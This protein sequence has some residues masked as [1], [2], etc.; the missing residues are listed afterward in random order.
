MRRKWQEK[1][2]EIKSFKVSGKKVS[3]IS[4]RRKSPAGLH[5]GDKY[6]RLLKH[7]AR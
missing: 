7:E 6:F 4:E 1:T 3:E 2:R 5:S